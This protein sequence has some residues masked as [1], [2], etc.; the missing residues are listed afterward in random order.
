M[1]KILYH[2]FPS[3]ISSINIEMFS[4]QEAVGESQYYLLKLNLKCYIFLKCSNSW[5]VSTYQVAWFLVQGV[6]KIKEIKKREIFHA[7][8]TWLCG[9]ISDLHSSKR[10]YEKLISN[11][12]CLSLSYDGRSSVQRTIIERFMIQLPSISA[13]PFHSFSF[14][15]FCIW[16]GW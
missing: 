2:K 14:H 6:W 1:T 10:L 5:F 12:W 11:M 3:K 15:S 7:R 4:C 9:G 13:Y 16:R 8:K